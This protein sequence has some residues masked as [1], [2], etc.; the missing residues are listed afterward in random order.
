MTMIKKKCVSFVAGSGVAK[1][2]K[3][4]VVWTLVISLVLLNE[5][6]DAR[7][8]ETTSSLP[9]SD[10][11]KSTESSTRYK[12]SNSKLTNI[13]SRSAFIVQWV[14]TLGDMFR[15]PLNYSLPIDT[16]FVRYKGKL[17]NNGK[18]IPKEFNI[19]TLTIEPKLSG[20]RAFLKK[21]V[22]KKVLTKWTD[23]GKSQ[24][25]NYSVESLHN[26]ELNSYEQHSSTENNVNANSPSGETFHSN[27][28]KHTLIV[29]NYH[30]Y[31]P[32]FSTDNKIFSPNI[33]VLESYATKRPFYI[34]TTPSPTPIITNI[35]NPRPWTNKIKQHIST[36]LKGTTVKPIRLTQRPP[37]KNSY[38]NVFNTYTDQSPDS[39]NF[40]VS[41]FSP[42]NAYT[43]KIII[44]PDEYSAP[45]DDCPTIYLTLNNTFQGQAKEACPDLNIAV[46][47][48]VLNKNVLVESEEEE[49]ETDLFPDGFGLP[50]GENSESEEV[51]QSDYS[52]SNEEKPYTDSASVEGAGF[53]NY[54][55]APNANADQA[56]L[57]NSGLA[58]YSKPNKHKPNNDDDAFSLS[59]LIDFFR[60]A[61]NALGWLATISPL[62]FSMFS[63][64]LAPVAFLL[65]GTTGLT[66]LFAPWAL[67]Y[68]RESPQEI[69]IYRPQWQWDDEIK[70]WYLQPSNSD[71]KKIDVINTKNWIHRLSRS[72]KEETKSNPS[73]LY[74]LKKW[75][76]D[77][78]AKLMQPLHSKN[79][80]RKRRHVKR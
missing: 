7:P 79:K 9:H 63:I 54:N 35:G 28:L 12:H 76:V 51:A 74:K 38:H 31:K 61:M 44:R 47:T 56:A 59:S 13:F 29:K 11:G 18:R 23:N 42:V 6:V 25:F 41:T 19:S 52:S 3:S 55:A 66:A 2:A 45:S 57:P 4:N 75:M 64:L 24:D 40:E 8:P 70:T 34:F 39:G 71:K 33:Q 53:T 22:I 36:S 80:F 32:E 15:G 65:V 48:N 10:E 58:S 14:K 49:E 43:E 46:N 20:K 68:A 5:L 1:M 30:K 17:E 69:H 77:V 16:N 21:P 78:S 67:P 27:N 72:S 26:T 50:L 37:L 60:P 62:G 73:W